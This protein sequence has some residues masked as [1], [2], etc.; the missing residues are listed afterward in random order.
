VG[1]WVLEQA[2]AQAAIWQRA[3]LPTFRLAVNVS[4]R[5]FTQSLPA[6]VADT[7]QRYQLD[8]SWLELEITESTLMHDF[9]RVT[10]IMDRITE[11]GVSLS[12]DDFGTG[13]SSL[14][15]LKRF[16]IHTLKIDRSFTTG[17]PQDQSDCAIAGTIVSMARQLG[18]RVIAEGVET[19]DQ[20]EFLREAGCDEVQGYLY[21]APLPAYEFEKSL[22][23]NWLLIG[24]E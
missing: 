3:G 1:E 5:E 10:G 23:E 24:R 8:A 17:I 12:L 7:L 11:L 21:A 13:Y 20:L 16:P 2:C 19:L 6:R 15:Y 14:S 22:R 18:L 9:E 4:A